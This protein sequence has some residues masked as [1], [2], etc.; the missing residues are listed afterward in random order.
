MTSDL[1]F[2]RRIALRLLETRS[3]SEAELRDKL[4]AR[5]VPPE[6]VDELMT[7][8][9]EVGLVD[10]AAFARSLVRTRGEIN[11]HGRSRIRRELQRRGIDPVEAESALDELETEEEA[12]HA[13]AFATRRLRTLRGLEPHVVRRRLHGALARRGFSVGVCMEVVSQLLEDAGEDQPDLL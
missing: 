13:L 2:A 6:L 7:R 10:D 3:R 4:A 11:R 9:K 5:K 12:A 1:E 8:F